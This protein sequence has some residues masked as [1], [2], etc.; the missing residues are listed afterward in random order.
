MCVSVTVT[1]DSDSDW[2]ADLALARGLTLTGSIDH[3]VLPQGC[4]RDLMALDRV[5]TLPYSS[6][7]LSLWALARKMH[8]SEVPRST[9]LEI[10]TGPET[11]D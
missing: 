10:F 9:N 8:E 3:L 1:P 7:K 5:I 2:E 4:G 11:D 6:F